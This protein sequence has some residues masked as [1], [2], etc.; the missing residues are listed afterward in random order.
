M[1][2]GETAFNFN[3]KHNSIKVLVG[4]TKVLL[5]SSFKEIIVSEQQSLIT[6]DLQNLC[7]Y[8]RQNVMLC[9]YYI[10]KKLNDYYILCSSVK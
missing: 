9:C 8:Q 2:E 4:S 7:F 1:L 5:L 3:K 10:I 6:L